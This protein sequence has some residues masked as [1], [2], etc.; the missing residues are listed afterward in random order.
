MRLSG[1]GGHCG[2]G[3]SE[4][5]ALHHGDERKC[6]RNDRGS[7]ERRFD[8][9]NSVFKSPPDKIG[10]KAINAGRRQGATNSKPDPTDHFFKAQ[11]AVFLMIFFFLPGFCP[12]DPCSTGACALGL[13]SGSFETAAIWAKASGVI[14]SHG[15]FCER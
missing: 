5:F 1:E 11:L 9:R 3:N 4:T 8:G 2:A 13:G 12:S 10:N 14:T 7:E 6:N 15:A